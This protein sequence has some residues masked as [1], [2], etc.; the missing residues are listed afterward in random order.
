MT[1]RQ[2]QISVLVVFALF[3]AACS[4]PQQ[5]SGPTE[6]GIVGEN[7]EA[8]VNVDRS[9]PFTI[10]V[11]HEQSSSIVDLDLVA[12][13]NAAEVQVAH[14]P[15]FAN[16]PWRNIEDLELMT[17]STGVQEVFVRYRRS[18]GTP[19]G[20]LRTLA[21]SILPPITPLTE[22]ANPDDVRVTR[23]ADDVLQIDLIAGEVVYEE[24]GQAWLPGPNLPLDQWWPN[25]TDATID[26]D[27][28]E[29]FEIARQS[30]PVGNIDGDTFAMRHRLHVRVAE[31]LDGEVASVNLAGFAVP[32]TGTITND[33]FSP[34]IRLGELGWGATDEKLGYVTVWSGLSQPIG[35]VEGAT[36]R[37]VDATTGAEALA[38]TGTR[39]EN[40]IAEGELWRGDLTGAPTTI[41]DFSAL[42]TAGTYRMCVD[43][44]GCSTPF[45]I[46]EAG[47]WQSMTV[48]VAR[49]LYHQRSGIALEQPYT[50]FVRP[51]P[52]HPDDGLV[53]EATEQTL[54]Q[55]ANGLGD[56]EKFTELVGART[57]STV[58]NA[59]GGH[60]DAGD[61]DRRIQHLWAA[62][63]LIDLVELFPDTT[64]SL[65]MNIPE[66]GDDVPDLL[67][68]ARWTVDLFMRLQNDDGGIRGGVEAANYAVDGGTSWTEELDVFAYAPDAWSAA[69][70]AGVAADMAFVLDAYDPD[71]AATYLDSAVRAMDWAEANLDTVPGQSD[72]DVQREIAAVSLYR[73]TGDEAYHDLFEE[74]SG[75][76][77]GRVVEPCVLATLCEANWRYATL[78]AELGQSSIR[79]NAIDSIVEVADQI[80]FVG[81]STAFGWTPEG[82][83]IQL[84]WSNG[85][86]IPH[87]VGIMRAFMLTGDEQYRDQAVRNASF[88]LGGNPA[89][90]SYITGVG[91]ENPRQPL[92]IDQRN[93]DLPIWPGTPIYGIFTS[94]QLP[95][96][97]LNFF[98]RD[99]GATPDPA[100]WPTLHSFVDQGVFAGH[101]EFTIQQSHGETIWTF[102]VLHGTAT[103]TSDDALAD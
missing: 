58:D 75:L 36:A 76:V 88:A 60:F 31:P 11:F 89:G 70:Y 95:E 9:G 20:E 80:L 37:I 97:Y 13:T 81:Q 38:V 85:P 51:R 86:S 74:L 53:V 43:D 5:A 6:G 15:T 71:A 61:W 35:S 68:E 92:L 24:T 63:R 59:W 62:R 1:L 67:D 94:W 84:I 7:A 26:G 44:L 3:A 91:S 22:T 48:T 23:V 99:A 57:G 25:S 39:F 93:S 82:P 87:T 47:P 33:A 52:Y 64:G 2:I 28:V 16:S 96:W 19:V 32:V 55:D 27:S 90:M 49:A 73:A 78:P 72:I 8:P 10:T 83:N 34:A 77:D 65:E 66:S 54:V 46:T 30:W 42:T 103:F 100:G 101:S 12:P 41:F 45:E 29:I 79:Q 102:G 18:D 50:A 56:G 69:I 98:L 4:G 21:L 17:L 14:E 40:P